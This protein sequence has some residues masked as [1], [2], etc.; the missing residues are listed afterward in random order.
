MQSEFF[1][2]KI[3]F[4]TSFKQDLK[5]LAKKYRHIKSDLSPFI[6]KL[7]DKQ[8][9]G[10]RVPRVSK[11]VYKYRLRNSDANSGKRSG[12]RIVYWIKDHTEIVLLTIYSKSDQTDIKPHQIE[13]LIQAFIE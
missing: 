11:V 10:D 9:L 13:G 5:R 4:T 12:Y 3:T 6:E 1:P 7:Q 2:Q 8:V